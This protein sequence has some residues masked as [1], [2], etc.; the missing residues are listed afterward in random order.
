MRLLVLGCDAMDIALV[1]QWAAEG[2][3]PNF[4]RL[5]ESTAWTDYPIAP[6][7]S[8]G[9]AWASIN[10][11]V[12][13]RR[14][15]FFPFG[16]LAPGSYQTRM[17]TASDLKGS[18][19]WGPIAESGRRILLADV[20]CSLPTAL[21][22][23]R[24]FFGWCLHDRPW[25]SW[26]VPRRFLSELR[27]R[28][29]EHPVPA[30]N[31]YT[32]E[33]D[34]ILELRSKLITGIRRR[35]DLLEHLIV[36]SDWDF[37]YGSFSEA[38]CAGHLMW[39]LEDA[40]HPR[41]RADQLAQVGP[42]LREVYQALDESMGRLTSLPNADDPWVLFFSH[43]VGPNHNADHLFPAF[44]ERFNCHWEGRELPAATTKATPGW[45]ESLWK[46]TV[47]NIPLQWRDDLKRRLP[48]SLRVWLRIQRARNSK[49]W[50]GMLAFPFPL[51]DGYSAVRVNLAGREPKGRLRAGR[52]YGEYLDALVRELLDLRRP[53]TGEKI[54]DRIFRADEVDDPFR[55]SS[56][57]DL[58]IWWKKAAR[59]EAMHSETLGTV[60]GEFPDPR[61]GEH[62][63]HGM[64]MVSHPRSR[65]GRHEIEGMDLR[66]IPATICELAGV[67]PPEAVEG[68]S[69][70]RELLS[71]P[72]EL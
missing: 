18:P 53:E 27:E 67:R 39:H 60:A 6:E 55:L 62:V 2:S 48:A 57:P 24:G 1:R 12:S 7:F 14:H 36:E 16:R 54:V 72:P 40:S 5:L 49:N 30:C 35:T 22:G 42:A 59:I 31:D 4:R 33:T 25:G 3:L 10:T 21:A 38:H 45:K 11:G 29:G 68:R 71:G 61:S 43:G 50:S 19:F 58:I 8:S 56:T 37:F 20:P 70:C 51:L 52:E 65:P 44:L 46:A 13:P 47:G 17:T 26:S 69:R 63:M 64:L 32:T 41:H 23:G 28:F 15:D 66:D 34:S 9:T